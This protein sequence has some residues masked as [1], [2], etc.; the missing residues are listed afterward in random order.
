MRIFLEVF[1]K[2]FFF[3]FDQ[4]SVDEGFYNTQDSELRIVNLLQQLELFLV[5][6]ALT[7]T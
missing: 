2:K 5:N 1:Y 3:I 7:A 4:N 6:L